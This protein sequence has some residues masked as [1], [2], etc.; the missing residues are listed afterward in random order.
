M[1]LDMDID[2]FFFFW[3]VVPVLVISFHLDAEL[4]DWEGGVIVTELTVQILYITTCGF[5]QQTPHQTSKGKKKTKKRSDPAK[6][7][8]NTSRNLTVLEIFLILPD[9][10]NPPSFSRFVISFENMLF[11]LP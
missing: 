8:A 2:F 7:F 5:H 1:Y 3:R 6:F 10:I 9:K 4:E 11:E